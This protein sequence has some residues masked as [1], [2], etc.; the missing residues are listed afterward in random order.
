MRNYTFHVD[1]NQLIYFKKYFG[2]KN[3]IQNSEIK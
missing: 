1:F 2:R 3:T